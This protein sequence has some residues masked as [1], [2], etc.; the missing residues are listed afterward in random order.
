M[1]LMI[2]FWAMMQTSLLS[3]VYFLF[4]EMGGSVRVIIPIGEKSA[5]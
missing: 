3:L 1:H 2:Y 5:C 4:V